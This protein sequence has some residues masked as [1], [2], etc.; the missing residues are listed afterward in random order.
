MKFTVSRNN[1]LNRSVHGYYN[2]YYTGYNK[3]NNPNFLNNLKNTFN[4]I[5]YSVLVQSRQEVEN[6]LEEDILEIMADRRW[7][8]CVCITIP[9]AKELQTYH[10]TQLFFKEAVR[11][12][13]ANIQG[14]S[15]GTDIIQR[16]TNTLT[17]HLPVTT[18]RI[19]KDGQ[20]QP[21]DGSAPYPGITLNTCHIN[22]EEV[23]NQNVILID[24]IYTNNVNIDEDCIQA[25]INS[26]VREIVFYA[27]AYTRRDI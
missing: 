13:T 24:D 8:R 21:N 17:T 27:V 19:K 7:D 26:G 9:R 22:L 16:H 3:P 20:S 12:A 18:S 23:R 11:N 1:F 25:L 2:R 6:I 5:S 14:A 4:S 15:D 10:A